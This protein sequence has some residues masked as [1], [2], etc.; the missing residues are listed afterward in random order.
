M[1]ED[2]DTDDAPPTRRYRCWLRSRPGMWAQYDGY[3]DVWAP[4]E[5]FV[6]SLAVRQ[7][8][9]GAFPDRPSPYSWILERIEEL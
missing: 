9:L 6:F 7:L 1:Y 4:D 8:A 3:V 5:S 2:E